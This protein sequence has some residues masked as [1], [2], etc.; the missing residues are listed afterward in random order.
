SGPRGLRL[1]CRGVIAATRAS[2]R[3]DEVTLHPLAD[4]GIGRQQTAG[5]LLWND[6]P[7]DLVNGVLRTRS[8][9]RHIRIKTGPDGPP[10][11]W[12]EARSRPRTRLPSPGQPRHD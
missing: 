6:G 10:I 7:A 5:N 12:P 8:A 1:G 11:R 2:N 9:L 4:A 3:P